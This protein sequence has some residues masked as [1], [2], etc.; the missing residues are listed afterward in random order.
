[1]RIS[2]RPLFLLSAIA[3]GL[4]ASSESRAQSLLNNFES[5]VKEYL[6]AH[7][8]EIGQI[9]RDYFVKH[10]EVLQDLL[11]EMLKKP[12]GQTA[13]PANADAGA[14]E[15]SARVKNNA[16][17]IFNS[18]HQTTFGD[19]NGDATLVEFFDYNCGFCKR[20]LT[21][22]LDLIRDNPKLKVVL[23]EMPILGPGSVEAARV[24]IAVRMQDGGG[25]KSLDFHRRLL[26][27]RGR[28]DKDVALAAARDA[29]LDMTRIETDMASDEVQATL[30]ESL[31]L[32]R[33]LSINGTPGYV[34]GNSIISGA[35]GYNVLK[36]R[37]AESTP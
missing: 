7:P 3:I 23:K 18:T 25:A 8:D 34:I 15:K 9:A 22:M 11:A 29:G 17:A 27:G 20:A 35:A 19:P 14:A 28:A 1:M 26:G 4:C 6:S 32:A 31:Q 10:P 2:V 24:A 30:A 5:I 16:A 12:S 37:L 36:A 21:D 33:T 13:A